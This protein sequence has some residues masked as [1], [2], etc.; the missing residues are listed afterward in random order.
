MADIVPG[1]WGWGAYY[2]RYQQEK[3]DGTFKPAKIY[4]PNGQ[5]LHLAGSA[6]TRRDLPESER[7]NA[8]GEK[9]L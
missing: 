6:V 9:D 7:F 8:F 3:K 4:A 1:R 5:L 2:E